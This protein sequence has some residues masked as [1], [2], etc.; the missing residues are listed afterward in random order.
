MA[1]SAGDRDRL[2]DT[3]EALPRFER[4]RVLTPLQTTM[5]TV[6]PRAAAAYQDPDAPLLDGKNY[7]LGLLRAPMRAAVLLVAFVGCGGQVTQDPSSIA[8]C[9]VHGMNVSGAYDSCYDFTA[10]EVANSKESCAAV[11]SFGKSEYTLGAPCPTAN[12]TGSCTVPGHFVER[13]YAPTDAD[14]CKQACAAS[15]GTFGP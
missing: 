5:P 9:I 12:R 15:G 7:P 3:D 1:R 13:C 6:D 8:S 14:S 4:E 10:G 2:V 11:A